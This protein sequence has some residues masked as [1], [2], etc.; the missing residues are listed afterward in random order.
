MTESVEEPRLPSPKERRRL[1]E[2]A[3]LAY[4]DVATAVGVTVSTVRSWETGRTDP[5]GRKREAYA[6]FLTALHPPEAQKS[7]SA[8]SD[9]GTD[10]AQAAGPAPG[11]TDADAQSTGAAEIEATPA[12]MAGGIR[13]FG[14]GG[15][16]PRTRPPVAAKRATR[17]PAAMP[18]HV[19]EINVKA[20][21]RGI[22]TPGSAT[23]GPADRPPEP[24][25]HDGHAPTSEQEPP[26]APPETTP[27]GHEH[28]PAGEAAPHPEGPGQTPA[29]TPP[30]TPEEHGPPPEGAAAPHPGGPAQVPAGPEGHPQAPDGATE[31]PGASSPDAA[32]PEGEGQAPGGAEGEPE[33]PDDGAAEGPLGPLGPREVFDAL[34]GYAAPALTRQ[35]YLLTGRRRLSQEAVERAFQ[36]AWARWPEV[37]TDPDPVG[38]VRAAA[39]EYA[40]S[41]WHRFRRA[42]KHPDKAPAAPADR[43]LMDAMLALPPTHRRTVLLYDGVGL[44]LPDTAAETEASTPTAGSRLLYAHAALADRIP[45]LAAAPPEKRSALLRERLGAVKPAVRLEPR[46][47][48]AVRVAAEHRATRWTRAVLGLSAVIAVATAYTAATAPRQYEPPIAPGASVSGVPP[49]SGPQ[50]L[51]DETRQL[52]EKLRAHPA[53]RPERLA[54][55]LE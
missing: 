11:D 40:L 28:A 42:H 13:P 32:R 30:A 16:G 51:T 29:D 36:L 41:P 9:P 22:G 37:A 55:G 3:G 46:A 15:H 14:M 44:D 23:S 38:W 18:R 54:P 21:A 20:T 26:H 2:A 34:Y 4:E 17:P 1:R 48:A 7:A 33:V 39:Y 31:Q 24:P 52:R 35:V 10:P 47:A 6:G 53:H 27:E 50:R 12:R 19:A 8:E 5:R 45:E 43:I 49:L 25:H